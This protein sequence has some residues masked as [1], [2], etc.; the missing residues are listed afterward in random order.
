M[1][2]DDELVVL[3]KQ[4]VAKNLAAGRRVT[5]AESCTGGLVSALLTEIPGASDVLDCAFVTYSNQMKMELLGVPKE[6][7][8]AYG[9]VSEE[10]VREMA[11]GAAKR[12][13]ADVAVAISGVAGPGGG[14]EEKP[15]GTVSFARALKT[16]KGKEVITQTHYFKEGDRS[17]VRRQAALV[18]LRLLLP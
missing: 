12:G 11:L 2:F 5:T 3:A 8:D 1:L 9:A 10:T 6:V 17:S 14:T 16:L 18:A 13:H 15:V 4:V 7:L